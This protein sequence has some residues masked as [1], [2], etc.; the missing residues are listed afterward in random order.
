VLDEEADVLGDVVAEPLTPPVVEVPALDPIEDCEPV[1]AWSGGVVLELEVD[2]V[3]LEGI[4]LDGVLVLDAAPVWLDGELV[5]LCE[6]I[7][8]SLLEEELGGLLVLLAPMLLL[9]DGFEVPAA[10][11]P[12]P[13]SLAPVLGEAVVVVVVVVCEEMLPLWPAALPEV[14]EALV[15]PL[16]LTDR[17]S[18]TLLTPGTDFASFLASFL[19]SLLATVPSSETTPFFTVICTFCRFGLEANCSCTWRWRLSSSTFAIELLLWSLVL[20]CVDCVLLVVWSGAA[21]V[22]P[23]LPA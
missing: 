15:A 10:T 8:D 22:W 4:E 3:V 19:S 2:G 9:E 20:D 12:W 16:E 7:L 14:A 6:L 5:L 21:P 1:A 18:F 23:M 13:V 17:C 11:P